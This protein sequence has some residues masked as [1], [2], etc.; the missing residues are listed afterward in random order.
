MKY[1][2]TIPLI[3][4]FCYSGVYAQSITYSK[5]VEP[6]IAYTTSLNDLRI[7]KNHIYISSEQICDGGNNAAD[8]FCSSI[9]KTDYFGN[10]IN[11]VLL[12]NVSINNDSRSLFSSNEE[13]LVSGHWFEYN[14]GRERPI[15][16]LKI[17]TT[18]QIIDTLEIFPDSGFIAA[19]IGIIEFDNYYY[20]Y[21]RFFETSTS[22]TY[23]NIQRIRKNGFSLDWNKI[24]QRTSSQND[25]LDLQ[26][27]H[28]DQLIFTHFFAKTE[29]TR[30]VR[31]IELVKI[32]TAGIILDTFEYES[33]DPWN[34]QILASREGS[35]FFST[36]NNPLAPIIP[37]NGRINKLNSELDSIEWSLGLPTDPFYNGRKYRINDYIQASNGDIVACGQVWEEGPDGPLLTDE[38]HTWNG[39]IVR[40]SQEGVID[41]MHIY[42]IPND[43][44]LLI[45]K[46]TYGEFFPSRLVSIHETVDGHF[47]VGG[48]QSYNAV[49]LNLLDEEDE[50]TRLWLMTV[51]AQ[52]CIEGEEC[53]E[54][55]ILDGVVDSVAYQM[56][57]PSLLWIA[58]EGGTSGPSF[59]RRYRF[60]R[61]SQ[62]IE[63][64][65]YD[66]YYRELLYSDEP[67]GDNW[68]ETGNLLRSDGNRI[69]LRRGYRDYLLYDF[70]LVEGDT[71]ISDFPDYGLIEMV[72]GRID[73]VTLLDNK[74]RKQFRMECAES[75]DLFYPVIEGI[76]DLFTGILGPETFCFFDVGAEIRCFYQNDTLVYQ[77]DRIDECWIT[78]S[79]NEISYEEVKVW[80]NPSQDVLHIELPPNILQVQYQV[81]DLQGKIVK[82]GE[83]DRSIGIHALPV[84][85]YLLRLWNKDQYWRTRFVKW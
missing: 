75:R 40:A 69:Y 49:Q 1:L 13:L 33:Y 34:D 74:P 67:T 18:L 7:N 54:V 9:I 48:D 23:S 76:G 53:E 38:N 62:K 51:D 65:Y 56:L 10:I 2:L 52:G 31:G 42:R 80:P 70:D 3:I 11:S 20:S 61:D 28:D 81:F 55:I 25:V 32:D 46:T 30:T 21:G 12:D 77:Q 35:V 39:F 26:P 8:Y 64:V 14:G 84:G 5:L 6:N 72:V 15:V 41:W 44:D 4:L 57:D 17:D 59:T 83:T 16:V 71:F 27:T 45:P 19:N 37:T 85:A 43:N 82:V 36:D 60:S 73:T 29:D 22:N 78:V 50:Q 24:Y 68:T 63:D 58:T 79:T 66:K 47:I